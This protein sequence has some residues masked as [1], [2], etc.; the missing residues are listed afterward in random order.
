[1]GKRGIGD[2]HLTAATHV[3]G[4][5]ACQMSKSSISDCHLIASSH[6]QGVNAHQ[7][8]KP[9]ISQKLSALNCQVAHTTQ[10]QQVVIC[11]IAIGFTSYGIRKARAP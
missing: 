9:N 1:M 3:Q 4:V 10:Q 11:H 2:C 8:S 7:M 6:V 5:N